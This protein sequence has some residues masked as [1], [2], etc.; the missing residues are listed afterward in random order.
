MRS[1]EI[2]NEFIDGL[3]T[4]GL[5]RGDIV[6]VTA[7]LSK[8]TLRYKLDVPNILE[9]VLKDVLGKEGTIMVQTYTTYVGRTGASHVY[10]SSRAING[11]FSQRILEHEDS[12]RSLHPINSFTSL[13]GSS[14]FLCS[15]N[16]CNN[17]GIGSPLDRLIISG[18]KILRIGVSIGDS[19]LM[20]YAESVFGIPYNYNKILD[21]KV[22]K[23]GKEIHN[24]FCAN[25]R[26]LNIEEPRYDVE[27]MST[28]FREKYTN[29]IMNIMGLESSLISAKEMAE[30]YLQM[31]QEDVWSFLEQ[32]PEFE[33]GIV[34]YD[35]VTVGRDGVS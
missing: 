34:P 5:Q 22:F 10:E 33:K 23:N 15:D 21:V 17:Y 7:D 31:L 4:I 14:K 29:N 24:T 30:I 11:A 12:I 19:P 32:K 28:I 26:Y 13:G 27:K 2:R 8:L 1:E 35:G 16:S 18:G 20:H 25:V 9:L 6:F 3:T